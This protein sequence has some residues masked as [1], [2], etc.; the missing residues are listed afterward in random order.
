MPTKKAEPVTYY[1]ELTQDGTP[2]AFE[3][4]AFTMQG[5]FTKA[6]CKSF[7]N[8]NEITNIKIRRNHKWTI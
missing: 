2:R 4:R 8:A 5:A 1:V 7:V 6:L 3:V